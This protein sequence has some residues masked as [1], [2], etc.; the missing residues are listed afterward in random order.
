[1]RT[2]MSRV[3]ALRET[4]RNTPSPSG[5]AAA[6]G[7]C[8]G[9]PSARCRDVPAC[10]GELR[11]ITSRASSGRLRRQV[12]MSGGLVRDTGSAAAQLWARWSPRPS[13]RLCQA[14]HEAHSVSRAAATPRSAA[15]RSGRPA[16]P[17]EAGPL[18]CS[19]QAPCERANT[20]SDSSSRSVRRVD[21]IGMLAGPPVAQLR[22]RHQLRSTL[23]A[24]LFH[25]AV[26]APQCWKSIFGCSRS[27]R[28][29]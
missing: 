16:A 11:V 13:R 21:V 10:G 9:G 12:E 3:E 23:R 28:R 5:T 22:P 25:S 19:A 17:A 6:E 24:G 8:S 1:M 27:R 20:S 29:E 2:G 18:G 15:R 7:A 14:A 4:S 26:A